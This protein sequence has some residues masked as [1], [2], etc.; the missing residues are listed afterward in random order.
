[1][2]EFQGSGVSYDGSTGKVLEEGEFREGLLVTSKEELEAREEKREEGD[3]GEEAD[4][5]S[6]GQAEEG[7]DP[8]NPGAAGDGSDA[9]APM[10]DG[11]GN[12][13]Q[14]PV[15]EEAGPGM[16]LTEAK[17]QKES[18]EFGPGAGLPPA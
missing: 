18:E 9:Q 3:P 1:M 14:D 5:Q 6:G 17:G 8:Q 13:A 11:D 10:P 4:A 12:N 15:T 2:G 16:G 7:T